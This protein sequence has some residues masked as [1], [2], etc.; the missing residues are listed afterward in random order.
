MDHIVQDTQEIFRI[1]KGEKVLLLIILAAVAAAL[2]LLCLFLYKARS[3]FG[4]TRQWLSVLAKIEERL[5]TLEIQTHSGKKQ[6]DASGGPQET[7]ERT[8]E[9]EDRWSAALKNDNGNDHAAKGYTAKGKSGKVYTEAEL[10][11][12]IRE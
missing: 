3:W 7:S 1:L 10:E 4:K 5:W 2:V 12:L 11:L 8:G 6:T 9:P